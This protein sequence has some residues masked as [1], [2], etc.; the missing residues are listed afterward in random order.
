V[1]PARLGWL[2]LLAGVA[3]AEAV[4][5]VARL[6]AYLKWP[7]DLL[8]QGD[9]KTAGILA[10]AVSGGAAS[11]RA[12][13]GGAMADAVVVGIGLNTSLR[14]HELPRPDATSLALAGAASFDRDPILRAVLR[15]IEEWYERWR[16]ADGDADRSG[17]R[18]AYLFHCGTIGRR[19]RVELPGDTALAGIAESVDTDG[20]LQVTDHTGT[21][22]TVAAGDVVH[23]R[24]QTA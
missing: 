7:N 24:A 9:R 8:V 4:R 20:R 1:P 6:D 13:S 17:L 10:E 23:V 3:L 14:E 22:H 21:L 12:M 16:A 2:P 5:R 15:S 19:V 11:G 18:E